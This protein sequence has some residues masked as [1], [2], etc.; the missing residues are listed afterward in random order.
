MILIIEHL[1]HESEICKNSLRL[2][3]DSITDK[4][5]ID[6][7]KIKNPN[8]TIYE[9]MKIFFILLS[10]N[11][12]KNNMNI[13]W[14]FLQSNIKNFNNIKKELENLFTKDFSKDIIDQCMQFNLNYDHLKISLFK[15][16]KNLIVILDLIK[17]VV[18][19]NIKKNLIKNLYQSN[20]N[21][22]TKLNNLKTE[23]QNK[24]II[25]KQASES[26]SMMQSELTMILTQVMN[27]FY[28]VI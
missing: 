21:K 3:I 16:N 19:F 27:I 9:L 28:F 7:F 17:V 4:I 10:E 2:T 26:L 13:S 1:F 23:I 25:I 6:I 11:N 12:N 22:N 18:D 8:E 24:E 20:L 5:L 15:I 14:L